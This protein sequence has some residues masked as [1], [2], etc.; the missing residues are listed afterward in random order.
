MKPAKNQQ[1]N[2]NDWRTALTIE[3]AIARHFNSRINLIVPNLS[4]GLHLGYE[5]DLVVVTPAK[6]AYEIEIKV[7]K[8]DLKRD[9]KKRNCHNSMKFKRLYFAVPDFMETY[10]LEF[11]PKRS[12]LLTVDKYG[13]VKLIRYPETNKDARTLTDSEIKHLHELM[14]MRV[15]NLKEILNSFYLKNNGN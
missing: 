10:A 2:G 7:S 14:S 6:Y 8:S 12:G 3:L 1:E 15:W 5:A 13:F 11:I 9:S 4:W